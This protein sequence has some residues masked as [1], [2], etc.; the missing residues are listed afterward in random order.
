MRTQPVPKT[1]VHC[2]CPGCGFATPPQSEDQALKLVAD[3]L[4]R[5]HLTQEKK[6]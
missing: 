5:V 4:T 1:I 6:S 2:T 3:H